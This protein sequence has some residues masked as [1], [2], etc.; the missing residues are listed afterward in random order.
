MYVAGGGDCG[1]C[2]G[3]G[4]CSDDFIE[5]TVN[6]VFID[7]ETPESSLSASHDTNAIMRDA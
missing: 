3:T 5:Q 4:Q 6:S 2:I 1:N 7:H